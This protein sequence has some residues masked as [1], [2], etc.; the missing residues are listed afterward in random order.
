MQKVGFSSE[1]DAPSMG[2]ICFCVLLLGINGF[3]TI[4][5]TVNFSVNITRKRYFLFQDSF[6]CG[7]S[8]KE[9]SR[10]IIVERVVV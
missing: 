1:N 9:C 5:L 4:M 10:F 3:N 6:S 7:A 2:V 8:K